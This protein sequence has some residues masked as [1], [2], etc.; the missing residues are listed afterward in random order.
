MSSCLEEVY[1][2]HVMVIEII[3]LQW[4]HNSANPRESTLKEMLMKKNLSSPPNE[5][6]FLLNPVCSK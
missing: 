2:L 6:K 4:K 5:L 3:L 1:L